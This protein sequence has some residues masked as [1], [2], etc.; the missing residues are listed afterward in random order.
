MGP[1]LGRWT[2]GLGTVRLR[3][4][5][6]R[7]GQCRR[8]RRLDTT[9]TL[10]LSRRHDPYRGGYTDAGPYWGQWHSDGWLNSI[11][12]NPAISGVEGTWH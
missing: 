12:I 1:S 8:A 4:A 6:A 9:Q 2:N 11:Q 7:S 10:I 5:R 3:F